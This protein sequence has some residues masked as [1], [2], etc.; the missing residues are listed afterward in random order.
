VANHPSDA[1]PGKV[2]IPIAGGTVNS[3]PFPVP[4][5]SIV[6]Q[7]HVP[8][9]TGATTVKLQALEPPDSDVDTDTWRDVSCFNL[10]DGT[11]IALDGIAED[12]VTVLPVAAVGGG[13]LR[14]VATNSQAAA[15]VYIRVAFF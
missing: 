15:P 13:V 8:A 9:L 5:G 3:E 1:V 12:A 6:M 11:L 2:L 4:K 7:I 14:F 10:A